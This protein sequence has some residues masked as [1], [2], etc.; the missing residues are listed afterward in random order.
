[1]SLSADPV[2]LECTGVRKAF[3][4]RTVLDG[5]DLVV[6]TGGITSILGPSGGGKTTLLRLVAGF[7]RADAG[8]IAIHGDVVDGVGRP[9]PPHRR[10]VGCVPQEG[11]LFP[12]L[13]VG[14]NVGFGLPRGRDRAVRVAECLELVGLPGTEQARPHELSGGQQQRIALA[15]AIAPR[16][17]LVLL[18]E[19]FS[20]LDA[21]LRAQVRTEVCDAVRRA[22]ATAVLVTHDQEEAL[23]V[24][25]AVAVLLD[26]RIRQH[27]DPLTL[28]RAPADL[29]VARFVGEAVIAEMQTDKAL[30]E[31]PSPWTGTISELCGAEGQMIKVGAV[32]VRYGSGGA[33]AN[34]AG[35][36]ARAAVPALRSASTARA[37]APAAGHRRGP[38]RDGQSF[39][40]TVRP[41]RSCSSAASSAG[42]SRA[43]TAV[44][45]GAIDRRAIWPRRLSAPG[46]SASRSSNGWQKMRSAV[47]G[48]G[49]RATRSRGRIA[50]SASCENERAAATPRARS[51]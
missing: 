35:A 50:A 18:D 48:R 24:S 11:A 33:G 44:Q 28:Y 19:P 22:G 42:S 6:P 14:G 8:T 45:H 49:G 3:G 21:G 39:S 29:D 47:S 41:W 25:D 32:L 26:G 17:R 46:E 27:A 13:S 1:M 43:A 15:R 51:T 40:A 10:H 36:S 9:V 4:R 31:V 5:I 20:S 23:S 30:V 16:P 7:D 38:K 34:A 2:A 37:A 12:H